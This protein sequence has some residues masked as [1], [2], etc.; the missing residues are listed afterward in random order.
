MLVLAAACL[1]AVAVPAR[2][3]EDHDEARRLYEEG[4]ILPLARILASAH[5]QRP[6]RVLEVSLKTEGG[7]RVYEIEILDAWGQVWELELD[8]GTGRLLEQRK[9]D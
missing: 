3:V 5:A 2:S 9:E 8:A 1:L 7:R 6:G 4:S